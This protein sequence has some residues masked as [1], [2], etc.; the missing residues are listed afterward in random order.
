MF[1]AHHKL[2]NLVA[3]VD[4]N[5]QQAL[6]YTRDILALDNMEARWQALGWQAQTVNGHDIDALKAALNGATTGDSK[7]I[8]PRV[9]IAKTTFGHGVSYMH[10]RIEWHYSPMNDEQYRQAMSEPGVAR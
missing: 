4:L 1:A 9:A 10:N 5:G 6:G 2:D 3:V 8:R 7:S